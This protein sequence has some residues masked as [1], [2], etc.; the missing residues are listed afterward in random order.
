M[1]WKNENQIWADVST[2]LRSALAYW[3]ITGWEL[4]REYQPTKGNFLPPVL[5]LQLLETRP[6]GT[7]Q[8]RY[9]KQEDE[10]V[11]ENS[12]LEE[13]TF[14]V[15]ALKPRRP[16]QTQEE[17]SLDVLSKLRMWFN[18]S[19]GVNEIWKM[20]YNSLLVN[21]AQ[22]P[23]F[24]TENDV[25]EMHP[26]LKL[27]LFLQQSDKRSTPAATRWERTIKGV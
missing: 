1:S 6:A 7:V 5:L 16:G 17:T 25:F 24:L 2:L 23:F 9:E 15:D 18:G 19:E 11:K 26:N 21:V 20:G 14:Q 10:L 4:A 27:H 12:Q 22:V 13:W 8:Q 3:N